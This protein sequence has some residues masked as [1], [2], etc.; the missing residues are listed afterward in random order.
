M[1]N[2]NSSEEGYVEEED[3]FKENLSTFQKRYK[4]MFD[5]KQNEN[6]QVGQRLD[7]KLNLKFL[8]ENFNGKMTDIID[9]LALLSKKSV[10]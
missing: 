4:T 3:L 8:K 10:I 5:K 6:K 7:K 9:D 1:R 2:S